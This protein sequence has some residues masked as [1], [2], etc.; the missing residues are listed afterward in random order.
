[1]PSFGMY[2]GYASVTS[3]RNLFYW[4]VESAGN[5]AQGPP[6]LSLFNFTFS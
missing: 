3:S 6:C 1:M 5:P 4:F 2:T